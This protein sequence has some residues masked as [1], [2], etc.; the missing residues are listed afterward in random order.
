M[1]LLTHGF[2]LEPRGLVCKLRQVVERD[3]AGVGEEGN[4]TLVQVY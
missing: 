2:E 4:G 3:L 1:R